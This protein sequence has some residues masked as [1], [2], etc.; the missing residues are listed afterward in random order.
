MSDCKLF[1]ALGGQGHLNFFY[2]DTD[3]LMCWLPN[4]QLASFRDSWIRGEGF[5]HHKRN[6]DQS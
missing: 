5:P 2:L 6:T 3:F 1:K 4:I